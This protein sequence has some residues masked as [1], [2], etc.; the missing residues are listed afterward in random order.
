MPMGGGHG[1]SPIV[2]GRGGAPV[3]GFLGMM[4][5]MMEQI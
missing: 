4:A 3:D 5:A 2:G 1:G